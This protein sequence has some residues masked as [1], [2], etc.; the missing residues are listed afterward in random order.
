M[1]TT[2]RRISNML[3]VAVLAAIVA[4]LLW[5]TDAERIVL[6][7]QKKVE[8]P[9]ATMKIVPD[10]LEQHP[11]PHTTNW[12]LF[13]NILVS[14][15]VKC[16]EIRVQRIVQRIGEPTPIANNTDVSKEIVEA[17]PIEQLVEGLHVRLHAPLG[18]GDYLLVI[19]STCLIVNGDSEKESLPGKAEA[20]ICFRVPEVPEG[21]FF[22]DHMQ[23]ISENCSRELSDVTVRPWSR[24]FASGR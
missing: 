5:R 20:W 12:G 22:E 21:T 7:V 13:Y 10:S 1:N 23:P 8:E 24:R 14:K 18:S 16:S 2:T 3:F 15:P 11:I 17:A 6:E 19:I 9:Y 4:F